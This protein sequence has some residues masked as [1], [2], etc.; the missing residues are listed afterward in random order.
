MLTDGCYRQIEFA[1]VLRGTQNEGAAQQVV[2]WLLSPAVQADLPLS[3]FVFPAR[4]NSPLPEVF[5]KFA[6]KVPNPLQL[7][8]TVVDAN[9][10]TWLNQWDEVM[11]R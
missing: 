5:T 4:A 3:M 10:K 8:A 1:G 6:T 11:N 7:P 9:L 2:D